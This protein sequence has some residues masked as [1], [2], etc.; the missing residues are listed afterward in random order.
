MTLVLKPPGRGS[1]TPVLVT[2]QRSKHAPLPLCVARG[3]H[4][5]L[6]GQTYR[7]AQVLV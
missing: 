3:Q 7:V 5:Q 1:W 6:G 2:I 4:V